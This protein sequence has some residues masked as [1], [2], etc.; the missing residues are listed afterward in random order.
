MSCYVICHSFVG[1][2]VK[3]ACEGV[4][5]GRQPRVL[6][7]VGNSADRLACRRLCFL[8]LSALPYFTSFPFLS[9]ARAF[10]PVVVLLLLLLLLLL[11][12]LLLLPGGGAA[13]CR[14]KV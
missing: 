7:L 14:A 10:L 6:R 3:G 4:G 5:G 13:V 12:P 8:C 9:P 11:L 2:F 1:W